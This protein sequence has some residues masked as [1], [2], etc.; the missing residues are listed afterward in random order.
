MRLQQNSLLD[1]YNSPKRRWLAAFCISW[2][3]R[4]GRSPS[5]FLCLVTYEARLDARSCRACV[6]TRRK[7]GCREWGSGIHSLPVPSSLVL[8]RLCLAFCGAL[9]NTPI[10]MADLFQWRGL[11]GGCAHCLGRD[12]HDAKHD[13]PVLRLVRSCESSV[14]V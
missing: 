10:G 8:A 6:R 11:C 9:C 1:H 13:S 3:Y 2:N 7:N 4:S 5:A 12:C 14:D